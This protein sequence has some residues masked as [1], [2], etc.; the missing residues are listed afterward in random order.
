MQA[1]IH[2]IGDGDDPAAGQALLDDGRL[3]RFAGPAWAGSGLRHLRI[4]QRVSVTLAADDAS[5][6]RLW[7]RGIGEGEQIR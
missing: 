4:G 3:V 2:T 5:V 7:I 6:S 1:S